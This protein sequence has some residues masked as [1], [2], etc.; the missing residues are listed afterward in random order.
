MKKFV[1]ALV[2]L[3]IATYLFFNYN[4]IQSKGGRMLLMSSAFKNGE[5]LPKKYT[6]DGQDVNPSLQWENAPAGTKSFA[7]I[8]DDPDAPNGVWVHWIVFNISPSI[9]KLDENVSIDKLS[10]VK[11]GSNSSNKISFQGACPPKGHGVHH[12]NF[13]L[14]A[15]NTIVNLQEGCSKSDLLNAIEDH[16]LEKVQIMATYERK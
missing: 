2:A 9:S 3:G 1:F 10:G 16:V 7:L 8:V 11:Q 14:Y 4:K 6:C 15:L 12:Y 5:N 13:T